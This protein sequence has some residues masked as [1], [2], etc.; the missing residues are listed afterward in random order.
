ME[1]DSPPPQQ[2]PPLADLAAAIRLA[3][4]AA[5]ALSAPSSSSAAAAA[6]AT[7]R[8]AHAAIG[9]FLS[10]LDAPAA[11]PSDN[12]QP[13]ADISEPAG[14]VIG[15]VEDRLREVALQGNK[16][17]KRPVPPSW[18]LGRRSSGACVGPEATES[19]LDVEG[20]R[21]A[22]MDLLLQFHA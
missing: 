12:D 8:D 10:R 19:V 15:E 6:A 13:M 20:R 18:P 21:G 7:L 3:A 5:A 4:E 9:S 22:A 16:R 14:P 1:L 11:L 2:A 17:R